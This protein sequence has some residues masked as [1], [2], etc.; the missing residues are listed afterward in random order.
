MPESLLHKQPCYSP[1]TNKT[2]HL[3]QNIFFFQ[4]R[5]YQ[6]TVCRGAATNYLSSPAEEESQEKKED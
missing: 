6:Q 4:L 3:T 2:A 5:A 1:P